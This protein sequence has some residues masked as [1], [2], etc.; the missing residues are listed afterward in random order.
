[1]EVLG[2]REGNGIGQRRG[3]GIAAGLGRSTVGHLR[4]QCRAALVASAVPCGGGGP[5]LGGEQEGGV[6]A[7]Y[8]KRVKDMHIGVADYG[9]GEENERARGEASIRNLDTREQQAVPR[10]E[11]AGTIARL[12]RPLAP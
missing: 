4:R 10:A 3:V 2:R 1:M 6:R 7:A 5:E 11:A 9:A 12:L 8:L